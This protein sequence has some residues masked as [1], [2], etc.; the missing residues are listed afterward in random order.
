MDLPRVLFI[1]NTS[2]MG[3]GTSQSL[4]SLIR[5]LKDSYQTSVVSDRQSDEL[6]QALATYAVP[7][8][9]LHDRV[10]RYLPELVSLI[11]RK[12]IDLI[13]ANNFSGRVRVAFW[14][15]L[16]THRPL[17]W[18]IRETLKSK[19]YAYTLR[20]ADCVIANSNDTAEQIRKM[21]EVPNPIVIPNG[22]EIQN[23]GLDKQHA[24]DKLGDMLGLNPIWPRLINVGQICPRK[25]Q[26]D[27]IA[28]ASEVV[29]D[30]P[31]TYFIMVG[32]AEKEYL[33][34]LKEMVEHLNL[35]KKVFFCEYTSAIADYICGSDIM[36]HT[37][38]RE[39]QGRVLLEAMAARI[40][41]V[42]YKV[43]GVGEAILDGS[44]GLLVPFG[45]IAT[46]VKSTE[47]LLKDSGFRQQMGIK[48]INRVREFFTAEKTAQMVN[49]AIARTLRR[50]NVVA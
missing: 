50:K 34:V 37:A 44:T 13:Y 11:I 33:N 26:A 15:A 36:I 42:A 7:H 8:Y 20:Y 19:R 29:A 12:K 43:G 22:I 45:D 2:Q 23:F 28:V 49:G 5:Y 41:V 30:F 24:R 10:I 27:F 32:T 31:N 35:C 47:I 25:N 48:G 4:L 21:A 18:H 17:I 1:N 14:A 6:P 46:L 16:L 40:P 3:A 39:P 38:S 9:A